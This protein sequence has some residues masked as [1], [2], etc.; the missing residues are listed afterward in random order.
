MTSRTCGTGESGKAAQTVAVNTK[1]IDRNGG[2]AMSSTHTPIE[3]PASIPPLSRVLSGLGE[4]V[5]RRIILV[6]ALLMFLGAAQFPA[7]AA[8]DTLS[9]GNQNQ[10]MIYGM[11]TRALLFADDGDRRNLFHIDGGVENSRLGWIA[12]GQLN[13][14]ITAGAQVEMD[15]PLSN[16]AGDVNLTDTEQT[17]DAAAIWGIRIQEVTATHRRFGKLSL[18]QGDTASTDRVAIDLSG[19]DLAAGNNPADMAGGI[20][21]RNLTTGARTVAIGDVIDKVDGIDK[22]D[23][24]RYDLPPF[25]GFNMA[26]SHTNNGA[27]DV[28]GVYGAE[29]GN[30]EVETAAFFANISSTDTDQQEMWGG[31]GSIKHKSGFSLTVAGAVKGQKTGGR[32]DPHYIWGK[33]GYSAGLTDIGETHFGVSYGQYNDF[34]QNGDEATSLGFGIVQDLEPIGSNLWLLVRNH[35]LDRTGTDSFHDIFIVS[36]GTLFNF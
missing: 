15:I 12:E 35:E 7:F 5:Q 3:F 21:F 34:S 16:A 19:S 26:L 27:W 14:D 20:Q 25:K 29:F 9:S 23:R 33:V 30:F 36:A 13:E 1:P 24:I 2:I 32:D 28:G 11:V 4:E 22:D 18:G 8:D 6:S 17:D 31:S 10:L